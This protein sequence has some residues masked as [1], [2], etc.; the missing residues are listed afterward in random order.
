[1]NEVLPATPPR[2][3]F[4]TRHTRPGRLVPRDAGGTPLDL[5]ALLTRA[6]SLGSAAIEGPHG[7]GKTNLLT[8]LAGLLDESDLLA[9]LVR[10]RAMRDGA[11]VLR[12][13]L[14][15]RPGT[16][17]CIDSWDTIGAAWAVA[18]RAAAWLCRV[19]LIVTS[20][21]ATGMPTVARCGTTPALLARLVSE[22][23]GHG[24]RIDACDVEQAFAAHGGDIREALYDLYDRFE[25]RVRT[26]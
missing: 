18:V 23:P 5:A 21:R 26:A 14:R 15:A 7:V 1:M 20:H 10:P 8:T 2:N 13:V 6:R 22:L 12:A 4:A 11:A 25:R 17:L 19:G 16:T 9:G 3:P 24:G